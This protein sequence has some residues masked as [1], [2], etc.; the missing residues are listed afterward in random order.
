MTVATADLMLEPATSTDGPHYQVE[1][2]HQP[3]RDANVI[4]LAAFLNPGT[5]VGPQW[6]PLTDETSSGPEA[7]TSV[8]DRQTAAEALL[9]L[10]RR[11]G[12]T[13]D[14][15]SRLFSAS[16]RTVHHWA[17]GKAPSAQH[18]LE[19]RRAL[20]AVRHLD[21]GNQRATRDRLMTVV[22]G[23]SPLDLLAGGHYT[24]GLRQSAAP[25][26][27]GHR[28]AALSEEEWA[29]R[30][31]PPPA[32]LLDAIQDRPALPV[33]KARIT[34]PAGRKKKPTE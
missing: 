2:I 21:E 32:L 30:R 3:S 22:N 4:P 26:E 31:P 23:L 33:G 24:E 27:T 20:D 5:T 6:I 29:K 18:E 7:M 15:L 16:R 12:L 10:R 17:N 14:L 1:A 8:P 25:A 28:R 9:E 11:S 34:R 19:I 13:W